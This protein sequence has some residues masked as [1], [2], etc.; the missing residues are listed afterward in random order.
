MRAKKLIFISHAGEDEC[1]ATWLS[2]CIRLTYDNEVEVFVSKEITSGEDDRS[3]IIN[4]ARKASAAISLL[5]P[6]ATQKTWVIFEAGMFIG[7]GTLFVPFIFAGT[8][9]EMMPNCMQGSQYKKLCKKDDIRKGFED[10]NKAISRGEIIDSEKVYNYFKDATSPRPV[11]CESLKAEHVKQ[12]NENKSFNSDWKNKYSLCFCNGSYYYSLHE[13]D[14]NGEPP[15]FLCS[16]CF[17]NGIKSIL[18]VSF[19][20]NHFIGHCLNDNRHDCEVDGVSYYKEDN[21]FQ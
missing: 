12:K 6:I 9:R 8:T 15:H 17:Q 20:E 11:D 14:A 5:S 13:K 3:T 19:K 18:K 7:R 16:A 2:E 21:R 10:I 4:N 1:H